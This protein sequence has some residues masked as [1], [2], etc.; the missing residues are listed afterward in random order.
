MSVSVKLNSRTPM[1]M[2]RKFTDRVPVIP[3]RL[4][5]SREARIAMPK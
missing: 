5:F 3:G 1:R 4:T 2:N